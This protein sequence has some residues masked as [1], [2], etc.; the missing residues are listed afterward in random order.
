[1]QMHLGILGILRT[2]RKFALKV[3]LS[4]SVASVKVVETATQGHLPLVV[5]AG[6]PATQ[7]QTACCT[8]MGVS[9]A[10]IVAVPS[11]G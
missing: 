7:S 5:F 3:K 11:V 1:V 8:A 10:K 2:L 4:M 9:A 6:L